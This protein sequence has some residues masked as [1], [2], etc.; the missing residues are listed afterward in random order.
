M[1]PRIVA[2][3]VVDAFVV[4]LT[5]TDGTSGQVDLGPDIVG[6][7]GV[8][9]ALNDPKVFAQVRVDPECGTIVF[10]NGVDLDPDALYEDAHRSGG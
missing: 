5:F 6:K 1:H 9:E 2:V 10:P 4:E 7:G 8:F 3:R